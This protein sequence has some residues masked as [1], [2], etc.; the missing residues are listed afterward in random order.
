MT[1]TEERTKL[2]ANFERDNGVRRW[3]VAVVGVVALAG[4]LLIGA[5]VDGGDD[6]GLEDEVA[7]VTA[8]RDQLVAEIAA[9]Q[10]RYESDVIRADGGD[11][12]DRQADM[13]ET[14]NDAVAGW[15]AADGDRVASHMTPNGQLEYLLEDWVFFVSDASLQDRVSSY[16]VNSVQPVGPMIVP[17]DRVVVFGTHPRG[18]WLT[19]FQF[20]ST[21]DVEV[22]G[23]YHL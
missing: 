19:I 23:V 15:Q 21:G 17:D 16:G 20:S 7:A 18:D 12:T 11:L 13:V 6:Q 2:K 5:L 14:T 22:I 3:I 10:E 1:V 4:G 9:L 8:E